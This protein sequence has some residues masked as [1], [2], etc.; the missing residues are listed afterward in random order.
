MNIRSSFI[1]SL[2]FLLLSI[3]IVFVAK[4]YKDYRIDKYK[5]E[6]YSSMADAISKE[7]ATLISEKKNAN[8]VIAISFSKSQRLKQALLKDTIS[9][10]TLQRYSKE[11]SESTE[12]KNIWIQLIN[13]KGINI[14]RSWTTK[15]GDDLSLIREDVRH[16][17][18]SPKINTSISVGIFDMSFKAMVPIY[19]SD[20]KYIGFIEVITHFNSVA[21]KIKDKNYEPV[22]LVDEKYKDQIKKPFTKM[23]AGNNYIANK[24]VDKNILENIKKLGIQHYISP[25]KK[26]II[27][28]KNG[29]FVVNYTMFDSTKHPMANFLV[30]KK[31]EDID[32]SMVDSIRNSVNIYIALITILIII[33]FYYILN[34]EKL[35]REAE[36]ELSPRIFILI[37]LFASV[38]YYIVLELSFEKK[39]ELFFKRYDENIKNSYQIIQSKFSSLADTMFNTIINKPRV[40]NILNKVYEGEEQKNKAREELYD[41]LLKDYEYFK[42]YDLRQLH[43][44]LKNN[45]SFLRFH[46]P[47][48]YGDNLKGVR[49]TVE[50]VNDNLASISGFE[51]GRIYNGFRYVFPLILNNYT[52]SGKHI[53]SV[54]TT[55][56]AYAISTEFAHVNNTKASFVINKDVVEKKVF[57]KE[58]SNYMPSPF[59]G[60]LYEKSIKHQFEHSFIQIN[61]ELLSKQILKEASKRI[62][63]GK[64]FS[65]ISKDKNTIFTFIPFRNPISKDVVAS[66]ILQEH[67]SEL[68]EQNNMHMLFLLSGLI[69][70]LFTIM[71]IYKEFSSKY[72][73]KQISLKTQKILDAQNSI[74]IL[75]NG[76]EVI[77]GN[78]KLL[79]YFGYVS[80]DDFRNK[81]SCIC[82]LFE[83]DDRFFHKGK[84]LEGKFW[85]NEIEKLPYKEHI[86]A[87]KDTHD[88]QNIFFVSISHF[89]NDHIISFSN[90]SDTMTEHFSLMER[91]VH[92]KLTGAYNRYYFDSRKD[93]WIRELLYKQHKLGIVM[94]DIDHFKTINDNYGH[95]RGDKVLKHIVSIINK[96]IRQEDILIRWGGEEFILVTNINS[97]EDLYNMAEHIRKTIEKEIFDMVGSVTCSFGVTL[98]NNEELEETIERADEALYESKK[99]GRNRVSS[100][101]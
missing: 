89:D 52:Q 95:G 5:H 49:S 22:I 24:N 46:R 7:V 20:L 6:L 31:L 29:Y 27:D 19:D 3:G 51:E 70:I 59:E 88:K 99:N 101:E 100:K 64:V 38:V 93:L 76:E 78:K 47:K 9:K 50:W 44:H 41:L 60:Y 83:K 62:K 16:M 1:L 36:F 48:V 71:Y 30:F 14:S 8:L 23:F 43:F 66:M 2:V 32:M 92:D 18:I 82:E 12:F 74:V 84:I 34:K 37:F 45:E 33:F 56:S 4:Q 68:K 26:Y 63:R 75:T 58:Q 81:Y 80:F 40:L 28:E 13:K 97:I 15:H 69:F 17:N 94:I 86:V 35:K 79:E 85:I 77:D 61:E 72:K 90:I 10:N 73:L 96:T 21:Q 11:L 55:F 57:K 91:V 42:K 39:Q 54:E 25:Y 67:N 98:Y 65:L 53:G 87:M